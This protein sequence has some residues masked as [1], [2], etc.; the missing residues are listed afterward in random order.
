MRSPP[1]RTGFV[2]TDHP[3]ALMWSDDVNKRGF[4]GPG[5]GLP[6]TSVLFPL[7]NELA[8]LGAFEGEPRHGDLAELGV[9]RV[10]GTVIVH[11]DKQVYAAA[12][13]FAW[14]MQHTA[15]RVMRGSELLADQMAGPP[16]EIAEAP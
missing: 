1:G 7:S 11:A 8:L 10:N 14:A 15:R 12:D 2:T 4:Y 13:D 6:K 16:P 9:A 3:V 5:F